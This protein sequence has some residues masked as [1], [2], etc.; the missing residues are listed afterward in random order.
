MVTGWGIKGG[1]ACGHLLGVTGTS[2]TFVRYINLCE[3][4]WK[5]ALNLGILLYFNYTSI[6]NTR[7][8]SITELQRTGTHMGSVGS[9]HSQ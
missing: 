6:S 8:G 3:N 5:A 2:H 1:Q 4:W 7:L 9:G